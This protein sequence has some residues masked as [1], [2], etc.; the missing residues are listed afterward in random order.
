MDAKSHE[1]K[2]A[3]NGGQCLHFCSTV[4]HPRRCTHHFAALLKHERVGDRPHAGHARPVQRVKRPQRQVREHHAADEAAEQKAVR[5]DKEARLRGQNVDGR[6]GGPHQGARPD[7]DKGQQRKDGA[8]KR[9]RVRV[10]VRAR[11]RLGVRSVDAR[12]D[13]GLVNV[14]LARR[15]QRDLASALHRD[16]TN[17]L[18]VVA[19]QRDDH[20]RDAGKA[21]EN[22][23]GL[24]AQPRGHAEGVADGG[25]E[26][27][28]HRAAPDARS[29]HD[30]GEHERAR[31]QNALGGTI[32]HAENELADIVLLPGRVHKEHER[33]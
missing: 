17:H 27:L 29:K 6:V 10:R 7:Q 18:G 16:E 12:A 33:H 26:Q 25:A 23:G 5:K 28:D 11:Q 24:C 9:Q 8:A 22:A 32:D 15:V 19:N 4:V 1:S 31:E 3:T 13:L 20:G 21:N 2:K 30:V 14:A